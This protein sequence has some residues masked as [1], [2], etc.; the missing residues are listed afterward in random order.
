MWKRS[1]NILYKKTKLED[2]YGVNMLA[3]AGGR[4]ETLNLKG[5]LKIIWTSQYHNATRKYQALLEKELKKRR[6]GRFDQG[7]RYH[8]SD[9]R[10]VKRLKNLKDAKA[11]LMTGDTSNIKFRV[12]GFAE[13]A[14]NC[15]LQR[16]RPVPSWRCGYIS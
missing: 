12:S 7:L 10:R 11:C 14:K 3:I 9:H 8:R 6:S 2:T 15:I 5:I 13:E 4:P 1:A 16:N